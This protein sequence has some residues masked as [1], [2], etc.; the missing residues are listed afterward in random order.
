MIA[1]GSDH[2]GIVLKK[3]IMQLLDEK[4]LSYKDFG[5]YNEQRTDYPIYAEKVA[6]AI[7]SNEC[8]KGLLFCGTGVGISIAANKVN[9]IR[10][11]VCS[12]CYSAKLSRAHNDTNILA[13]GSRVVG[14]DLAKLI[15]ETW[16]ET[17]YEGGRHQ[18][19]IDQMKAIEVK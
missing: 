1:L 11:V 16:L 13:L 9:G 17:A 8:D 5:T 4:N 6:N 14:V 18:T 12:D 3:E 2:I 10:A 19:R 7:T 15:V